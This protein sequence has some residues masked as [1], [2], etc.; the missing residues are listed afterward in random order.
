MCI[1]NLIIQTR[2][3]IMKINSFSTPINTTQ[4]QKRK[5]SFNYNKPLDKDSVSFNG[6][7]S[8]TLSFWETRAFL[9]K[10]KN[11]YQELCKDHFK[12]ATSPELI[13]KNTKKTAGLYDFMNN[14][15]TIDKRILTSKSYYKLVTE[16]NGETIPVM[17]LFHSRIP[18][19]RGRCPWRFIKKFQE[20]SGIKRILKQPLTKEERKNFFL[21][22]LAHELGGHAKQLEILL[23][24]KHIDNKKL[25]CKLIGINFPPTTAIEKDM[26]R[27]PNFIFSKNWNHIEIPAVEEFSCEGKL[28]D[29]L[30]E[31]MTQAKLLK[32]EFTDPFLNPKHWNNPLEAHAYDQQANFDPSKF[33]D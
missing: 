31:G 4:N 21:A 29:Q 3:F 6:R 10:V 8:S 7:V 1:F 15:V 16:K 22:T 28:A 13:F 14:K 27:L 11:L 25:L 9:Q 19:I 2:K 12:L 20:H 17:S 24:A 32:F 30:L 26:F 23:G 18:V 5:N 33:L